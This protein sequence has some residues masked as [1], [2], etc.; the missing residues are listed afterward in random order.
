VTLDFPELCP[1]MTSIERPRRASNRWKIHHRL[2]VPCTLLCLAIAPLVGCNRKSTPEPAAPEVIPDDPQAVAALEEAGF[3]LNKNSQGV[4]T[5]LSVSTGEDISST[6]KNLSGVPNV[7]IASFSG[8]GLTDKGMD[9]IEN[10]TKLQRL[11]LSNSAIADPTL[12][13]VAKLTS[14]EVLRLRRTSVSNDGLKNVSGLVGLRAIDLR[15]SKISD[16]GLEHLSGLEKLGDIELEKTNVTDAGVKKLAGLP[17]KSL[18]VNYCTSITNASLET[19]GKITTLESIQMDYTKVNDEGMPEIAKLKKLKRLRLR[20]CDVTGAGIAHIKD[21]KDINRIELR[22]SSLDD[23]GL[24][25]IASLPKMQFLD[26]AECRL[27]SSEG[28][29]QIAGLTGLTYLGLWETKIDDEAFNTFGDLVNVTEVNL[30]GATAI[31]DEIVPTL[32]KM[33]SLERLN[34]GGTQVGDGAAQL[35][36]LPN[37]VYLN[38]VNSG[39][40]FD[41]VDTLSAAK[42]NLEIVDY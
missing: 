15:N 10:L 14:L 20:G 34:V 12:E 4:V 27:V 17:L 21:L 38:I 25:V 5:E 28:M 41:V 30:Q 6:L 7:E 22:D 3:L 11:D 16:E 33:K 31:T 29:K 26:I 18:N 2:T 32:V 9:A 1:F 8:P 23:D 42:E 39:V 19:L 13:S 40:G 36:E 35:A 24:A 37:L